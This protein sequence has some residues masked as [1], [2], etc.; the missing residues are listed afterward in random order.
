MP[1]V[2]S[3][4]ETNFWKCLQNKLFGV[5]YTV[6]AVSQIL[7]VKEGEKLLLYV[8]GKRRIFGVYRAMSNPFKEA[9]PAKGPWKGRRMDQNHGYYPYRVQIEIEKDFGQGVPIEEVEILGVGIDRYFFNGKSVGYIT[10]HQAEIIE[11]LLLQGNKGLPRTVIGFTSFPSSITPLNPLE[12]RKEEEGIL[13]VM[14]QQNIESLERRLRVVDTYFP[15][16]GYGW[17]GQIDILA[18][19]KVDNYVVI[20]L[21]I[22]NLP[23][24]IWSQLLSYS[25][26]IRN[27]FA[28]HEGVGV[29]TMAVARGFEPK[30]LYAYPE[31]KQLLREPDSLKVFKF[32]TDFE[33]SLN[34]TEMHI[35]AVSKTLN[36]ND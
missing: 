23:A 12:I 26:A 27:I 32:E 20:E 25:Y 9:E 17:G 36:K 13:Q 35:Q 4:D 2:F 21:K 6:R 22:T 30:T 1:Y 28:I 8:Y 14:V 16:R 3:T 31:L 29:R 24:Q 34:L 15:V 7:N 33:T 10:E 18:K 19:D 11:N 5:P